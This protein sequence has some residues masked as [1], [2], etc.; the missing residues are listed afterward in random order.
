MIEA[1]QLYLPREAMQMVDF[2]SELLGFP[3]T[4]FRD[5]VGALSQ[6]MARV[7]SRQQIAAPIN[8]GPQLYYE[9][10]YGGSGGVGE[11]APDDGD[12]PFDGDP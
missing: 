1:G 9:D 5:Q 8:A 11:D 4:R 6:L 2:K 12:L 10:D 7:R 3:H